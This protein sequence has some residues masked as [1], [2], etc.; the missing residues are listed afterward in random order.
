MKKPGIER[1]SF[2]GL[3]AALLATLGRSHWVRAAGVLGT[4]DP[5]L[6]VVNGKVYTVDARQPRAEAFAV[7]DGRFLAVGST[8]EIRALAGANT[9]IFDAQQMTLV[10]GFN[11]SH[12]HAPGNEL[13]YEVLVGNPYDV[14]FVSIESIVKKLRER[15]ANTSP[16][17]WV[18]G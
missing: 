8:A 1:R 15:A 13:L 2:L 17:T 16:D 3:S 11:D 6:I 10:P 18:E 4:R 7:K 14:E 5:E 9:D 12:N